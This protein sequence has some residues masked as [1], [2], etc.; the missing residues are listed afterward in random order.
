MFPG[1]AGLP[2]PDGDGHGGHPGPPQ[3][4]LGHSGRGHDLPTASRKMHS[5]TRRSFCYCRKSKKCVI[6]RTRSM[7]YN[8]S[9]LKKKPTEAPFRFISIFPDSKVYLAP[10]SVIKST[11]KSGWWLFAPNSLKNGFQRLV[12]FQTGPAETKICHP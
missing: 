2:L 6:F 12:G 1:E 4:P 3:I 8:N 9:S 10:Y 5:T 7:V 11:S